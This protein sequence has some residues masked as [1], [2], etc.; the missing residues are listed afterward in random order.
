MCYMQTALLTE[1][2]RS[3][4]QVPRQKAGILP[5]LSDCD[6]SGK[7]NGID[8]DVRSDIIFYVYNITTM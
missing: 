2:V 8:I 3:T 7:E 1:I 5:F 6:V 4:E